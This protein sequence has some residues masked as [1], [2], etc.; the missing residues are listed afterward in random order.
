M[1]KNQKANR[2]DMQKA[3]RAAKQ[4]AAKWSG[5]PGPDAEEIVAVSQ[6]MAD[7]YVKRLAREEGKR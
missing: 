5:Q 4:I 3:A 1:A 2:A 6:A 7:R